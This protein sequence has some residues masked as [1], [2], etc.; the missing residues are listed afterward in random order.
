MSSYAEYGISRPLRILVF[1]AHSGSLLNYSALLNERG[2]FHLSLCASTQEMALVL[3]QDQFFD[4]LIYDDFCFNDEDQQIG[5]QFARNLSVGSLMVVGDMAFDQ[6]RD[7]FNW[8]RENAVPLVHF[9]LQPLCTNELE[10]VLTRY[11]QR[12]CLA[13]IALDPCQ[14][15]IDNS[16]HG[17]IP[18]E[19][20]AS[21]GSR[22]S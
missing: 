12:G 4:L 8:A 10:K 14:I 9:F 6:R 18:L 13:C 5:L 22:R 19:Q 21:I 20:T 3:A 1:C 17:G 7:L 16:L 15:E 2:V 11:R